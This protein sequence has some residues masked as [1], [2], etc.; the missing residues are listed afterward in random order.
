M[1][2]ALTPSAYSE[3]RWQQQQCSNSNTTNHWGKFTSGKADGRVQ[4]CYVAVEDAA[5]ICS[6]TRVM[7]WLAVTA[8]GRFYQADNVWWLSRPEIEPESVSSSDAHPS[9]GPT[10]APCAPG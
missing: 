6:S 8:C 7:A 9:H 3:L 1:I 5:D 4:S 2:R 10:H